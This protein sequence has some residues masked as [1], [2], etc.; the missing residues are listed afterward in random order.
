MK[1]TYLMV[2]TYVFDCV[3]IGTNPYKYFQLNAPTFNAETGIFSKLDIDQLIPEK[4][5]LQQ[6]LFEDAAVPETYP[7]F[8]KPEWGQNSSGII[9]VDDPQSLDEVRRRVSTSPI[10]YLVQEA[11]SEQQE[12]EIFSIQH[13]QDK[14]QFAELTITRVENPTGPYPVNGIYNT[15]TTYRDITDQFTA[16]DK[17]RLWQLM[18]EIGRFGIS[19]VGLRADSTENLLAGRFQ[20]IEVNLYVPMPINLL[21]PRYGF[22]ALW[23]FVRRYMMSL[24][25]LTKARDKTLKEKPVLTKMTLYNRSSPVLNYIRDR[26]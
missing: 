19:R 1:I 5:R 25:R 21:D 20:V 4:W 11:S 24:A 16:D 8:I 9:R 26:I 3:L 6:C 18:G 23:R 7:V 15:D 17:Q 22:F 12:Y 14:Q 10:K 2:A 13:H